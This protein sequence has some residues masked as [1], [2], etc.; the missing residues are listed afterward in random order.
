MLI[1]IIIFGYNRKH[2]IEGAFN[3]AVNQSADYQN[4]EVVLITNFDLSFLPLKH[5][6]EKGLKIKTKYLEG[7]IGLFIQEAMEISSGEVLCFL[8]DD[9]VFSPEK[10]RSV[11]GKFTENPDLVYY[12]NDFEYIEIEGKNIR[13]RDKVQM[14]RSRKSELKVSNK[15]AWRD[16]VRFVSYG[17]NAF[18]STISVK[19]EIIKK[20]E[21]LLKYILRLEDEVI[22]SFALDSEGVSMLDCD[23][24]T[25]YRIHGENASR[26]S[27]DDLSSVSK[28]CETLKRESDTLSTLLKSGTT[29]KTHI[30]RRY[31]SMSQS[32]IAV[33]Y[34]SICESNHDLNVNSPIISFVK[35]FGISMRRVH[36]LLLILNILSK[37][38]P[39]LSIKLYAKFGG[40]KY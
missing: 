34:Y 17:G 16:V 26:I 1:S 40:V 38:S 12:S 6:I 22:F 9:D 23:K 37:A 2:F 30:A 8:D 5:Y 18:N 7:P 19:K 29:I 27:V 24:L 10:V 11:L 32:F 3:S 4:Y 31:L 14:F 36:F 20:H 35:Y 13:V 21:S 15:S 25:Y 39:K 28:R 33:M